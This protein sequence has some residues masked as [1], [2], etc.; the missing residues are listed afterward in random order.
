MAFVREERNLYKVLV[1]KGEGKRPLGRRARKGGKSI[2]T[3]TEE[4]IHY[5]V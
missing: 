1:V 2:K 3:D 4:I 5:G